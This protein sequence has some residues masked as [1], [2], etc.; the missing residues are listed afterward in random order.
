MMRGDLAGAVTQFG[1]VA[2]EAEAAHDGSARVLSLAGQSIALAYQGDA[3]AARAAAD[4]ALKGAAELGGRFAVVGHGLG[5][6]PW[7]PAMA[8]RRTRRREAAGST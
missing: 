8:R 4:A 1:E 2:A 3:A 7:P 6:R 5:S